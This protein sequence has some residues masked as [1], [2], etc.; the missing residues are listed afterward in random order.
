[1]L[2][3]CHI[4]VKMCFVSY[5]I[6]MKSLSK[7]INDYLEYLETEKKRSRSTLQNYD[8]YLR[9]FCKWTKNPNPE[10]VTIDLINKYSLWLNK[11]TDPKN[12]QQLSNKTQNYH[13]IALRGFVKFLNKQNI[14]SLNS[15]KIKLKKQQKT[16]TSFLDTD[17]LGRLLCA[18]LKLK[19]NKIIQ[20]RDKAILETLFSTGLRVSEIT[21]LFR[22]QINF[23]KNEI[24]ILGQK[25]KLRII[26]I[27]DD[28]IIAIKNYLNKRSDTSRFLFIAHDRARTMQSR[29]EQNL[30]PRSIQRIVE[31]Y[32]KIAGITKKITPHSLRHS[33]AIELL[34]NGSSIKTVQSIL[35]HESITT[36]KEYI[37]NNKQKII[38]Y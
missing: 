37:H 7:N 21:K 38:K 34:S 28:A 5:N 10:K 29:K 31:K 24:T 8:L 18:P 32:S 33:F 3:N 27:S 30:S 4:F 25:N 20:S 26:F 15:K 17:E 6:Y 2:H 9:R 1:M 11:Y 16:E 22:K 19:I 14:K 36:T 13:L 12:N 23:K 35:G